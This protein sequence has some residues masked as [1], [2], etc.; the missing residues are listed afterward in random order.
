[1]TQRIGED[2]RDFRRVVS[3]EAGKN[4]KNYIT[5][6]TIFR[7]R[8]HGGNIGVPIHRI[9]IPHVVHGDNKIG[10]GRGPGKKGDIVGRDP[11]QQPG[12]PG[13]QAGDD[14]SDGVELQIDLDQVL[15]M[16]QEELELPNLKPKEQDFDEIEYRYCSLSL[17][18]PNSLRHTRKS[19]LTALKRLIIS[20]EVNNLYQLP[21][22]SQAVRLITPINSDFRYRQYKEIRKPASNA[23][24]FFAR[25][26]SY[27]MDDLKCDIV[28]DMCWWIDL[29]IRSFYKRTEHVYICHDTEAME[30]DEE[31]FYKYRYGGG[32][33]CSSSLRYIAEQLKARFEPHKWNVYIFYFSDGENYSSD[34]DVFINLIKEE[35]NEKIVNLFGFTQVLAYNYK[36]SLKEVVD[37]KIEA[38]YLN[39]EY[40]KTVSIEASHGKNFGSSNLTDSERDEQ[41]KKAIKS[42]LGKKQRK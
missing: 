33:R 5:R 19:L 18:G 6:G 8:P 39:N 23:V 15:K 28:S 17:T 37:Q 21:G 41:V 42:I 36:D 29:W 13:N 10:I 38:G 7:K 22:F 4:L 11:Q 1:M 27:S 40:V 3:G 16:I 31:K 32:T 2:R 35:L 12:Q 30:T 34:N 20:G 14:H 26:S 24:I 9:D 25:D